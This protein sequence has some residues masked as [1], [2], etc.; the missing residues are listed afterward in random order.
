MGKLL[1]LSNST[2][3]LRSHKSLIDIA[4]T[5]QLQTQS[6]NYI[7]FAFLFSPVPVHVYSC[8]FIKFFFYFE[9]S[10]AEFF[11]VY[12]NNSLNFSI[13]NRIMCVLYTIFCRC[14]LYTLIL[15]FFLSFFS[16]FFLTMIHIGMSHVY[17]NFIIG[18]TFKQAA[19]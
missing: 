1:L 12:L 5:I 16:I 6:I 14:V 4:D 9:S 10:H 18:N 13:S 19:L 3:E 17:G 2:I 8:V 15:H 11:F 7:W